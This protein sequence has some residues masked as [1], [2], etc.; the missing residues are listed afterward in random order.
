ML[1]RKDI[2]KTRYC[3][4]NLKRKEISAEVKFELLRKWDNIQ[5]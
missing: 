5:P 4:N 3:R 1:T 2:E